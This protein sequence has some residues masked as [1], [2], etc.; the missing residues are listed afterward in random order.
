MARR[1]PTSWRCT[2]RSSTAATSRRT[3]TRSLS[4][5]RE[6]ASRG[7]ADPVGGRLAGVGPAWLSGLMG[8]SR[9]AAFVFIT[10]C[11]SAPSTPA[12]LGEAVVDALRDDDRSSMERLYLSAASAG[13]VC[14]PAVG[15]R[16][17]HE[18]LEARQAFARC[19]R[20]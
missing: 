14:E 12:E 20:A 10:S 17:V 11:A 15:E 2:R 3:S 7:P 8:P 1:A 4:T 18:R 6:P 16:L 5:C 9:L 19:R 13:E